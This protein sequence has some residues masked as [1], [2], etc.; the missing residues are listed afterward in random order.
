MGDVGAV[1]KVLDTIFGW[2][3]SED[4]MI[5]WRKRRALEAKRKEAKDALDRHNWELLATRV[6]ELKRLSERP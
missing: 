2:V 4:G 1:A 3:T 6:A 5:E